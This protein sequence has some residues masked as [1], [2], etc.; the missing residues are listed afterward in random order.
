[1]AKVTTNKRDDN[2]VE[3]PPVNRQT[4]LM[5]IMGS[6]PLIYHAVSMKARRELLMPRG[7]LNSAAK[8]ENMKHDPVAEYRESFYT[9]QQDDRPTRLIVP[10][11]M[12]KGAILSAAL[13]IPGVMK[14]EIGQL[15]WVYGNDPAY[16]DEISIWG[17][18]LLRMDVVRMADKQRTP[19]I[20]TRGC[21]PQWCCEFEVQF[22]TP[23]LTARAVANL[24]IT[25]GMVA[26][27]CDWRPEKGKGDFGSYDV[28]DT[29]DAEQMRAFE[30]IRRQDRQTQDEA[31][32]NPAAMNGP[33]LELLDW[34]GTEVTK[35]GR[36]KAVTA[37]G[38]ASAA[39][40]VAAMENGGVKTNGK[41]RARGAAHGA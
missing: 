24:V 21:L 30:S 37:P 39:A 29:E 34:F 11:T 28:I 18:P 17:R 23:L 7:R 33:T 4:M 15:V 31:I 6:T 25:S 14:T 10:A 27:I 35:R 26:G 32:L 2:A 5:R 9:C 3:V 22:A 38:I 41:S 13:R 40:V 1:M 20:R 19:D 12:F 8:A 36:E 16:R